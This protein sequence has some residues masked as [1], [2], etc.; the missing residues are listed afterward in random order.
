VPRSKKFLAVLLAVVLF[1]V[2]M[3]L[4]DLTVRAAQTWQ[5]AYAEHLRAV[6]R[7]PADFSNRNATAWNFFLHDID[8][9]NIPELVLIS[10][11][12]EFNETRIFTFANGR[13]TRVYAPD[14]FK[15]PWSIN[16]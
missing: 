5:E 9:D 11:A 12:G 7:N 10:I 6:L 2:F 3:P 16:L 1:W 4:E 8:N 15:K 14:F 13:I